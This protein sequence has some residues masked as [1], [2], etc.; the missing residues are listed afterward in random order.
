MAEIAAAVAAAHA[1]GLTGWFG[2]ARPEQRARVR[3]AYDELG[4][5]VA[6]AELDALLVVANDHL[7]NFRVSAYPDFVVSLAALHTGPDEWFRPWLALDEYRIAGHPGVAGGVFE[8]LR[9][10]GVRAFAA[11]EP[12]RFDD[13][14][15]VPVAMLRLERLGVPLV[16]ILQNCTVPPVPDERACYTVGQA[17]GQAIREELAPGVRI[18]LMGSGGLSHEPGGPRYFEFDEDFDRRFLDLLV[19]GDHEVVLSEMTYDRM[20]EA[21][22]GGTSELLS[23]I[24][25]MGAIGERRCTCLGYEAVQEWRCGVGAVVWEV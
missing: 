16:P 11:R 9:C 20:E 3:R 8:G 13:N 10:R 12:L 14:V 7:G 6:E 1:P 5:V 19:K 18:G 21:G 17:L 4:R 15:S 25:V 23:W 24:V 22:A 2:K